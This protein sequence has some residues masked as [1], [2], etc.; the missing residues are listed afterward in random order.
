MLIPQNSLLIIFFVNWKRNLKYIQK[1][2]IN[3]T[4]IKLSP[5]ELANIRKNIF[6]IIVQFF[7]H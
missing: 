6:N 1:F 2:N 7:L 3:I 4:K 5:V